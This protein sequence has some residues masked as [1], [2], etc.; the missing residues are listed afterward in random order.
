MQG[1]STSAGSGSKQYSGTCPAGTVMT[2]VQ[3]GVDGG[4]LSGYANIR[5]KAP[6]NLDTAGMGTQYNVSS[7]PYASGTNVSYDCPTG[8]ALNQLR[9][10]AGGSYIDGLQFG[11]ARFADNA[12]ASLGPILGGDNAVSQ[13][14]APPRNFMTG[15]MGTAGSSRVNSVTPVYA[16][17]TR[18][19]GQVYTAQGVAD[20]CMGIGD[21]NNWKYQPG[22]GDCDSYLVRTF[23]QQ[24]PNDPRCSCILSEM[25]CPNKFDQNCIKNNG[26]RTNDMKTVTCPDVMNC[27]QYNRLSPGAKAL[28]TNF[29]QNCSSSSTVNGSTTG[30]G[31][32]NQEGSW[33]SGLWIMIIILLIIVFVV[34]ALVINKVLDNGVTGAADNVRTGTDIVEQKG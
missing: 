4:R 7:S 21:P 24:F 5:C 13:W 34:A 23:C 17:F 32:E 15:V 22:S 20:G 2:G 1:P 8:F 25:T 19:I 27:I 9:P 3:V 33:S 18:S 12:G 26:Y 29:Q 6:K 28:A 16:D 31:A 30:V 14:T 10:R 11:C